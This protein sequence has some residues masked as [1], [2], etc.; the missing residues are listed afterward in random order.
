MKGVTSELRLV[1]RQQDKLPRDPG[2]EAVMVLPM[3]TLP[4]RILQSN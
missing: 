4:Q 1:T 2:G 3:M